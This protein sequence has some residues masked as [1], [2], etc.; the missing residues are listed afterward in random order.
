MHVTDRQ[1]R[2]LMMEYQKNGKIGI[3]ALKAGMHRETAS[4]YVHGGSL[5]SEGKADPRA[6]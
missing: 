6:R 5:P 1:E 2:K 3:S 4:Q